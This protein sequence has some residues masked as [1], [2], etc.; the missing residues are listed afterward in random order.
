MS[1]LTQ[2]QRFFQALRRSVAAAHRKREA[3]RTGRAFSQPEALPY[4]KSSSPN[5][6][7]NV[8]AYD[9]GYIAVT[10]FGSEFFF[11]L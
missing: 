11:T 8:V 7:C 3:L 6:S 10:T 1:E 2:C 5:T 9:R 4:Y